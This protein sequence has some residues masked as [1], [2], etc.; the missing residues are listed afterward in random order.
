MNDEV[1][2]RL[3]LGDK[4]IVGTTT[5]HYVCGRL[6]AFDGGY[7]V[8]AVGAQRVRVPLVHIETVLPASDAQAEFVK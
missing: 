1:R 8:F 7:A 5:L 4:L 3:R 2:A 6:T